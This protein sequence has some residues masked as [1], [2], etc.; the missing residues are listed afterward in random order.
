MKR[1]DEIVRVTLKESFVNQSPIFA[2]HDCIKVDNQVL[3]MT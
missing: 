2:W 3:K 1:K